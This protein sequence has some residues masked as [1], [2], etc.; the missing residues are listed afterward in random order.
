MTR[1]EGGATAAGTAR[2][3]LRPPRLPPLAI[4]ALRLVLGTRLGSH[5]SRRR[6]AGIEFAEYRAYRP[7]DPVRDVDWRVFA[8]TDRLYVRLREEEL[9][10][11]IRILLDDSPS[12]DF[13]EPETKFDRARLAVAALA[14]LADRT[15]DAVSIATIEGGIDLPSRRG[16]AHRAEILRALEAARPASVRAGAETNLAEALR[17]EAA[18]GGRGR[19]LVVCTDFL[20]PTDRL[21]AALRDWRAVGGGLVSLRFLAREEEDLAGSDPT[22]YLDPETGDEVETQPLEIRSAYRAGLAAHL[23]EIARIH[24]SLGFDLGLVRGEE[25][26]ARAL[27]RLLRERA[28]AIRAVGTR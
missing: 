20:T 25:D 21:G 24:G 2:G 4:R 13:G 14:L 1:R 22:R 18:R 11:R 3:T 15:G 16:A 7:G 10:R 17:E 26:L 28:R 6:G 23:E 12:M 19:L 9:S 5:R 27:L 8:R